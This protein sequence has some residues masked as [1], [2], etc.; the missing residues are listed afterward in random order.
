VGVEISAG[1]RCN[2]RGTF[3]IY[4]MFSL[5][6]PNIGSRPGRR[7]LEEIRAQSP[8]QPWLIGKSELIPSSAVAGEDEGGCPARR[9]VLAAALA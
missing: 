7:F 6:L 3:G 5:G 9:A 8:A 4:L 2:R 1:Q